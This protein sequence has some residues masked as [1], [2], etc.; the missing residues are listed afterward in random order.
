MFGKKKN[1]V[2]HTQEALRRELKRDALKKL[3][4]IR[5]NIEREASVSY[6]SY[7][8]GMLFIIEE[9]D[10]ILLNWIEQ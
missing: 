2:K 5:N 3:E 7:E 10:D 4:H 9:L 8:E 1:K 6:G